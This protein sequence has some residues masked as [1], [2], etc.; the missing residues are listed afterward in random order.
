[1]AACFPTY[2]PLFQRVHQFISSSSLLSRSLKQ[3]TGHI[4]LPAVSLRSSGTTEGRRAGALFPV[5]KDKISVD[6]GDKSGLVRCYRGEEGSVQ[7]GSE[8]GFTAE[9]LYEDRIQVTSDITV[10]R[11][12]SSVANR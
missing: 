9:G 5:D 1:M 8:A 7:V 2:R 10:E 6:D 4:D 12:T 3:D 11:W